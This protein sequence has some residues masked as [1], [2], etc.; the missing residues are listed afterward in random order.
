MILFS[1]TEQYPFLYA[2]YEKESEIPD[3]P[4]I[5]ITKNST[6]NILES[7]GIDGKD[8][9]EE[10]EDQNKPPESIEFIS[11]I[12]LKI[13]GNF[14]KVDT[15][16]FAFCFRKEEISEKEIEEIAEINEQS[17]RFLF[18]CFKDEQLT[19]QKL[20]SVYFQDY[21]SKLFYTHHWGSGLA[22][23]EGIFIVHIGN[24]P[25][26]GLVVHENMHILSSL[27]WSGGSTSFLNEGIAMYVEALATDKDKNHLKTLQFLKQNKLF[28]LEEMV[29]FTIGI[30]GLKTEVAYPASGSFIEFLD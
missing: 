21:D 10:W 6:M 27:N 2:N 28:P 5:S 8:L 20:F 11:K 13:K 9:F 16:N 4:V 19:W 23:N 12:A 3:I 29:T 26:F 25:D 24:V 22:C 18:D 15:E 14:D 7:S 17:I 1:H 30:Q